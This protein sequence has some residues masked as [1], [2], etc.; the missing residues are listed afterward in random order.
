M[1]E[2]V[3]LVLSVIAYGD[4]IKQIE[5]KK[6][7]QAIFFAPLSKMPRKPEQ[8]KGPLKNAERTAEWNKER[9]NDG[10]ASK[11]GEKARRCRSE[12]HEQEAEI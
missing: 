8:A 2:T 4:K 6:S 3:G 9:D 11:G 12:A 5:A 7:A 10:G 1:G